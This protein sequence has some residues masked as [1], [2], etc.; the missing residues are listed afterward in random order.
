MLSLLE[1]G[2]SNVSLKNSRILKSFD[3]AN[4]IFL[5][6]SIKKLQIILIDVIII[7]LMILAD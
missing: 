4:L 1:V 5:M 2:H 3:L 7:F 6:S